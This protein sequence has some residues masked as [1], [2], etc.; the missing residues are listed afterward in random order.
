MRA[1]PQ[2]CAANVSSSSSHRTQPGF[3]SAVIGFHNIVRVLL[4]YVPC[5]RGDA[6]DHACVDRCPVCGD[7][8]RSGTNSST[9]HRSPAACRAGRAASMNSA[10]KVCT[11]R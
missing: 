5:G 3:E 8:D 11:Q 2:R 1:R 10:V 6:L 9:N 7:L 4:D